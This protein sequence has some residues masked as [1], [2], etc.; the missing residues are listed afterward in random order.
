MGSI[1]SGNWLTADRAR[2]VAA[3]SLSVTVATVAWLF[4]TSNGTLDA[5]GRPLGTDFSQVWTA[6]RMA[7]DGQA[8]RVWD[9]P[10]HFAVQQQLHQSKTV[11]LYGWHYP[12]PFLLVASL[13]AFLPYVT[14]LVLWQVVTLG[15]LAVAGQRFLDR[16]D[17]R[18][19][20]LGAP[21]VLVCL[22]HGQ[23]GFLTALLLGG[24]LALLDRRP[25]VAGLLFG[26]LLY[27]PQFALVIPPVLLF[28]RQWRAI[29]GGAV[30]SLVLIAITVAIWGPAPWHSFI[31]SLPLT[32]RVV[33]EAGT[34]GWYK[35]VSPFAAVR[36][37]G[38]PVQ[39]SYAVQAM[40]SIAAIGASI[41]LAM[42]GRPMLRNAAVTA[43]AIIA[44]PYVLDYD[45]VVLLAGIAFLWKDGEQHGWRDWE[46][47]ILALCWIAPLIARTTAL[48]TSIPLGL[49]SALAILG[50]A[51]SRALRA[52]PSRHSR[53]VSAP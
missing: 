40:F 42:R 14:A 5:V 41:W 2:L 38:L 47:P 12:P 30:S 21:V 11:E 15:P 53:A 46:R 25:F 18:L 29:A 17:G 32:K 33:I 16:R 9:W 24:G 8:A 23:N 31:D 39:P 45:L 19:F 7:L 44:T 52:S 35:L 28:A 4:L 48:Y 13:L 1:R 27:K 37:W 26:C 20:V 43:A 36:A 10:T 6:G 34:T 3:A 51:L 22:T 49:M 50:V